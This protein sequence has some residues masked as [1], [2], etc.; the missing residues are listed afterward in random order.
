MGRVSSSAG[1]AEGWHDEAEYMI[2]RRDAC[3]DGLERGAV[4]SSICA[5]EVEVQLHGFLGTDEEA[6]EN[7]SSN[8][9][10]YLAIT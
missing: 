8:T 3:E 7:D 5:Q 2:K 1:V 10:G 6:C 4:E 9:H